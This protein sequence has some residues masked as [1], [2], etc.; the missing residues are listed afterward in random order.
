MGLKPLT[1]IGV[2]LV[3][4]CAQITPRQPFRPTSYQHVRTTAYT[5][6][7]RDHY[8]YGR[9]TAI[10]T[11]LRAGSVTSCASDWSIYPVGTQF[12]IAGD[13]TLYE[14]DDYGSA[15]VGTH[16]IDIY[17]PSRAS[18]NKWGVK[19]VDIRI[20]R[21]G[22]IERSRQ[23]LSTRTKYAHIRAMLANLPTN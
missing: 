12:Q 2:L 6:N 10:G 3:S 18:M 5:H 23:I 13:P 16:T 19:F 8:K 14:I 4:S 7:E 17:K 20:I 11:T 9:S 22:C 1:L 15:L 21:W